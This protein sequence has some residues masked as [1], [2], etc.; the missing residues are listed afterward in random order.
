MPIFS[1]L[2]R[3]KM[4]EAGLNVV[5]FLV[6][7]LGMFIFVGLPIMVDI[8]SQEKYNRELLEKEKK[9]LEELTKKK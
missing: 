5:Y 9:E 3:E 2:W 6:F 7:L 4:S 1:V 8:R